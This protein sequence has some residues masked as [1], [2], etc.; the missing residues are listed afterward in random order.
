MRRRTPFFKGFPL[1]SRKTSQS[2]HRAR[3]LMMARRNVP[4]LLPR[5]VPACYP[6]TP[7]STCP[8]SW[9]HG[10]PCPRP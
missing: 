5:M 4:Q 3:T 2:R 8:Q 10:R 1:R 6:R 9:T 7:I